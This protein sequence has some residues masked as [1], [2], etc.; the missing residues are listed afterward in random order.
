MT[1]LFLKSLLHP[2]KTK[3]EMSPSVCAALDYCKLSWNVFGWL[4][5]HVR[6]NNFVEA[7]GNN[8]LVNE[9]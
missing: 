3:A 9:L 7:M 2:T 8:S 6:F 1:V 4:C 5:S